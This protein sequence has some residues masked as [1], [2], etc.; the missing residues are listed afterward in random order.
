M[1]GEVMSAHDAFNFQHTA[2]TEYLEIL[3][4][5]TM[6]HQTAADA[7]SG[8]EDADFGDYWQ[9]RVIFNAIRTTVNDNLETNRWDPLT[10]SDVFEQ[11]RREGALANKGFIQTWLDIVSPPSHKIP[12]PATKIP[13]LVARIIEGHF[14]NRHSDVYATGDSFTES[15][16]DIVSRMATNRET[17]LA[18]Y[19]RIPVSKAHLQ[20]VDGSDAA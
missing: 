5:G 3:L 19:Q 12:Q 2:I 10:P 4:S 7:T 18:I 8:L 1:K 15:L 20:A 11:L 13:V 9:A 16:D 14:R 6:T 17:L